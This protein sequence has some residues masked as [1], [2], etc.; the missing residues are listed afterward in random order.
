MR[1]AFADLKAQGFK[2]FYC[3]VLENN[4]TISFYEKAG[5]LKGTG[6]RTIELEEE[7]TEIAMEW[8]NPT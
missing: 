2:N 1:M 5:A 4:P 7:L 8:R 6:Q 3:W